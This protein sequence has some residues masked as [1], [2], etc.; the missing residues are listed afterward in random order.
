M[1]NFREVGRHEIFVT[2]HYVNAHLMNAATE[3]IQLVNCECFE[4]FFARPELSQTLLVFV[5]FDKFSLYMLAKLFHERFASYLPE[6]QASLGEVTLRTLVN[7]VSSVLEN[8]V[9]KLAVAPVDFLFKSLEVMPIDI[10]FFTQIL[11]S[12]F[13]SVNSLSPRLE[14]S[15]TIKNLGFG[16]HRPVLTLGM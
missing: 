12:A 16:A 2:L 8:L 14:T 13:K 7:K 4:E 3:L 1:E 11:Q 6:L 10:L 5:V 15:S 9:R